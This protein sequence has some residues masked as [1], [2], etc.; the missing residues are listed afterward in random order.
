MEK[1]GTMDLRK[2]FMIIVLCALMTA[3]GDQKIVNNIKL[4]QTVGYDAVENGI[5][6]AAV[7]ANYEQ[8]KR[9]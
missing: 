2:T 4:V 6:S 3:C 5:R 7:I 9:S 8:E 1:A